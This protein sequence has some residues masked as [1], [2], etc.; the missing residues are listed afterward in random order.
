M[1]VS[2]LHV[3]PDGGGQQYRVRSDVRARLSGGLEAP[4]IYRPV[5]RSPPPT[6]LTTKARPHFHH[7]G[8][9][10]SDINDYPESY[11][12]FCFSYLNGTASAI[13]RVPAS[14]AS[15]PIALIRTQDSLDSVKYS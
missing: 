4:L 2:L 6:P 13:R 7:T 3:L 12:A 8:C 10:I 9:R 14:A 5:T 11:A 15:A 1:G